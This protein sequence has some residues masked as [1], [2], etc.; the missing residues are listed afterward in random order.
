MGFAQKAL[1]LTLTWLSLTLGMLY[2][3]K[4]IMPKFYSDI[5][6]YYK[7]RLNKSRLVLTLTILSFKLAL[8][9]LGSS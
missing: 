2:E 3:L 6:L 5:N 1:S 4:R 8:F 9:N 7:Y